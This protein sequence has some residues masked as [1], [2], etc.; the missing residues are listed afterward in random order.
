MGLVA[1]MR[2]LSCSAAREIFLD[3]GSNPR[4]LHWQVD[5]YLPLHDRSPKENIQISIISEFFLLT[6][7]GNLGYDSTLKL[8]DAYENSVHLPEFRQKKA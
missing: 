2:G 6:I 8:A 7:L 1:V 5:S 3:Q 4:P